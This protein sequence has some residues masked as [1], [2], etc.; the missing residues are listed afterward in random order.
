MRAPQSISKLLRGGG[1][2]A[3]SLLPSHPLF[4]RLCTVYSFNCGDGE[5]YLFLS[6]R[7]TLHRV[8]YDLRSFLPFNWL[9][10][11]NGVMLD[12]LIVATFLR[13]KP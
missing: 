8:I 5:F 10:M 1:G 11:K 13:K 2:E 7:A 12:W 3:W 9:K 6:G 4:L